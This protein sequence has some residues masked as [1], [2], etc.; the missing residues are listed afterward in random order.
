MWTTCNW[1]LCLEWTEQ[2]RRTSGAISP[3]PQ[4]SLSTLDLSAVLQTSLELLIQAAPQ[5]VDVDQTN[6]LPKSEPVNLQDQDEV[7]F[8][9]SIAENSPGVSVL[10]NLTVS[11][12]C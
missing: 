1:T 8:L 6:A 5:L 7:L 11:W 12:S 2:Y 3:P 10:G 9:F 4:G